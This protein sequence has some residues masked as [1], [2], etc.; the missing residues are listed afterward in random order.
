M[1]FVFDPNLSIEQHHRTSLLASALDLPS[2]AA[3]QVKTVLLH[4]YCETTV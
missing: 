4:K 3:R 1:V 2:T